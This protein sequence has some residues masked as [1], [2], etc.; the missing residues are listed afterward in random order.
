MKKLI[1]AVAI[2]AAALS[3]GVMA[4]SANLSNSVITGTSYSNGVGSGTSAG[5][6]SALGNRHLDAS[7]GADISIR[8]ETY[9]R[10]SVHADSYTSAV[11]ST[12]VI[13]GSATNATR[14]GISN[15]STDSH[16]ITTGG[17]AESSSWSEAGTFTAYDEVGGSY[18]S[19]AGAYSESGSDAMA[20]LYGSDIYIDVDATS[21]YGIYGAN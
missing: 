12:S 15:F 5:S 17:S 11:N 2:V 4:G 7:D 14:V 20:A 6:E 10:T 13:S 18:S 3:A 19:E 21:A 16:T 9:S 1:L 8:D